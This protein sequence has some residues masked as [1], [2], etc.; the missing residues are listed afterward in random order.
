M[1]WGLLGVLQSTGQVEVLN[2]VF[3][4]SDEEILEAQDIIAVAT[5]ASQ[6]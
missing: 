5:K 1:P 4:P 3:M 6:R 2:R